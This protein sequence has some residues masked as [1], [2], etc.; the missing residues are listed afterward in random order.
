MDHPLWL[1][2]FHAFTAVRYMSITHKLGK[3]I[4]SVLQELV[5]ERTEEALPML[6]H[7]YLVNSPNTASVQQAMEPFIPSRQLS[8]HPIAIHLRERSL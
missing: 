7:L 5:R 3:V 2:F 6:R 4:A 8:D 1:E